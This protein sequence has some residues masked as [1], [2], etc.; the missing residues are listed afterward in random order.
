MFNVKKYAFKVHIDNVKAGWWDNPD[1]CIHQKIQLAVTEVAEATEGAR[2]G[3]MDDHLPKRKMEEVELADVMIRLLDIGGK[4]G[5]QYLENTLP[6]IWTIEENSTGKQHLGI[7]AS[8][9]SFADELGGNN[10]SRRVVVQQ[11][12]ICINSIINV[13]NNKGYDLQA[14]MDEKLEYNK[15]RADHK[16]ANRAKEGGK[17]F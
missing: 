3:L 15:N 6:H 7:T 4:Y 8:L 12:S 11:Y 1:E 10:H 9:V 5:I 14:A 17:K 16:P 13:S 2:K